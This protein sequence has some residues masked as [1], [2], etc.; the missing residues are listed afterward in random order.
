MSSCK[1]E[2]LGGS[3]LLCLGRNNRFTFKNSFFCIKQVHIY[4]QYSQCPND[5]CVHSLWEHFLIAISL[6]GPSRAIVYNLFWHLGSFTF[7]LSMWSSFW[8]IFFIN[9][10]TFSNSWNLEFLPNSLIFNCR[11]IVPICHHLWLLLS[12]RD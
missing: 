2:Y 8:N 11:F 10:H 3:G 7:D 9:H 6:N 5:I 1:S 4:T 12:Y